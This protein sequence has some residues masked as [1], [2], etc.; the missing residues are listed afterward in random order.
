[1]VFEVIFHRYHIFDILL[2]FSIYHLVSL[3]SDLDCDLIGYRKYAIMRLGV[4]TLNYK[5]HTTS[6]WMFALKAQRMISL[7]P[8]FCLSSLF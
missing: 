7:V 4:L 3:D 2:L 8:L 5:E 6:C 1:M